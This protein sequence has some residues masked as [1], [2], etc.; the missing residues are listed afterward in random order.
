MFPHMVCAWNRDTL[1]KG[2]Q[3]YY[4]MCKLGSVR[5]EL[6]VSGKV[7][8]YLFTVIYIAHFP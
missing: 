1:S 8:I 6:G 4:D 5:D 7:V 3:S 2:A